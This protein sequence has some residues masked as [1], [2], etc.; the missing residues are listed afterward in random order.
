MPTLQDVFRYDQTQAAPGDMSTMF[1]YYSQTPDAIIQ[2]LIDQGVISQIVQEYSNEGGA[3]TMATNQVDWSRLP[4]RGVPGLLPEGQ[5]WVPALSQDNL[6]NKDMVYNDPNYGMLSSSSNQKVNQRD[7]YDLI[8]PIF[9]AALTMGAGSLAGGLGAATAVAGDAYL[10]G[11]LYGAAGA[12]ATS[13]PWYLSTGLNVA[14]QLGEEKPQKPT[15]A[16]TY[17]GTSIPFDFMPNMYGNASG[18]PPTAPT[19][20]APVATGLVPNAYENS[21]GLNQVVT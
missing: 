20:N 21:Y 7:L 5:W 6:I 9:A 2:G 18:T 8:G 16:P 17:P 1:G 4:E 19:G 3:G 10:P 11:A 15:P 12:G 13:T 14:K